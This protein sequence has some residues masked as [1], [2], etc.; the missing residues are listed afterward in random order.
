MPVTGRYELIDSKHPAW[1]G[2]RF[3]SKKRALKA[4]AESVPPGR[5]I[6]VDRQG[7]AR[8]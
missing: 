4:L 1:K 2:Q 5:F 6:L 3:T 8:W 7:T